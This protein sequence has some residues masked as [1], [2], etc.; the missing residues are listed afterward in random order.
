MENYL[1]VY[2]CEK[3][4]EPSGSP[5]C[6]ID[7]T[8]QNVAAFVAKRTSNT[9]YALITP[10]DQVALYTLGSFM[11]LVPNMEYRKELLPFLIPM[12]LGEIEIPEVEYLSEE[13]IYGAVLTM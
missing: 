10:T 5:I 3:F 7:D 6:Y 13:Q 1:A 12:Q 4:R 9:N 8:P 2:E 11:D